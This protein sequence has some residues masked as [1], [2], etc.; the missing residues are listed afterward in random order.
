MP[1][2]QE[3][4]AHKDDA[5]KVL[6]ALYDESFNEINRR[7]F[8]SVIYFLTKIPLPEVIDFAESAYVKGSNSNMDEHSQFKY[9]CAICWNHLGE[10]TNG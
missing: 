3:V 10:I 8:M 4:E 2:K 1:T 9:F 7:K 5:W 6:H